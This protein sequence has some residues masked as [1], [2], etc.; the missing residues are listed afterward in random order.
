[1]AEIRLKDIANQIGISTVTVSNALSGKRGVSAKLREHIENVAMEL[2]YN[3]TRYR[4]SLQGARIGVLT[5]GKAYFEMGNSFYWALYQQVVNA[6]T[7]HESVTLLESVEEDRQKTN[8]LPRILS[9]KAVDG[10]IVIG[11]MFEPYMQDLI[12]KVRIPVV[13]LDFHV[14]NSL[15]DTVMSCNYT[16][17][18]KMTRYLID[19]GHR[20]IAFVG[21]TLANENI[22]D[23][24]YGYKK[25]LTESGI[26][27]N[28][29]WI[30]EDRNLMTG[31]MQFTLPE[32]LP[33]AFVCNCDLAASYVYQALEEKGLSVPEDASIVG[34]D[35]YLP[36]SFVTSNL[37]TY[38][39]DMKRMAEISVER[40]LGKIRGEETV[41]GTRYIDGPIIVRNS[42]SSQS[43]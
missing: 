7:T 2:G 12:S 32:T 43:P 4:R 13:L 14:R 21:S 29:S 35:D 30:L 37:T 9:N 20:K 40:L 22:M 28:R 23:R 41:Y 38:H 39:V 19:H 27:E 3:L 16:G 10:L 8:E 1:M 34:Y 24:Y 15:C 25:A 5:A 11:W 31:K 17:M 33:T 18:Y 26:Q 42:V 36:S 6:A